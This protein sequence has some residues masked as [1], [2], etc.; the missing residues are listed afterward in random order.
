MRIPGLRYLSPNGGGGEARR[1]ER[2]AF[3]RLGLLVR[4]VGR[5]QAFGEGE[6]FEAGVFYS[7]VLSGSIRGGMG[8]MGSDS[9][10]GDVGM[11][12]LRR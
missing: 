8:M 6:G 11:V 5:C 7:S 1:D 9:T 10:K 3:N 12:M 4:R 2:P